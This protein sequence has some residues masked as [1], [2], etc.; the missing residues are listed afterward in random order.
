[1]LLVF[2]RM[3]DIVCILSAPRMVRWGSHSATLK[4][5]YGRNT[6]KNLAW[7]GLACSR[8]LPDAQ[9]RED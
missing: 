7:P 8:I 2:L 6:E 4:D 5:I 1:M 3:L 9:P